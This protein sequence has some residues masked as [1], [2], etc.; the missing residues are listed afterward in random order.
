LL[1]PVH[2][3]IHNAGLVLRRQVIPGMLGIFTPAGSPAP[4]QVA[5]STSSK[6]GHRCSQ[7][8]HRKPSSFSG[9]TFTFGIET[10]EMS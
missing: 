3:F 9:D 10:P 7:P 4:G 5:K 2:G 6:W 1:E 8:S